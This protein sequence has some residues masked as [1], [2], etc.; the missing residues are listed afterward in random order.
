MQ[1]NIHIGSYKTGSTSIQVFMKRQRATLKENGWIYPHAGCR[2]DNAH[3]LLPFALQ[4]PVTAGAPSKAEEIVSNIIDEAEAAGVDNVILSSEVF[5]SLTEAQVHRLANLFEGHDVRIVA[6]F[7]R[8]DQFLHSFY[9]QCI[10]QSEIR[11]SDKPENYRGFNEITDIARYDKI[12]TWW[13]QAFGK[14]SLILD[15][16]EKERL[17]DGVVADLSL[18]HI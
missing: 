11:L 15:T 14:D 8:Q 16:F 9:M 4:K 5:F 13:E 3:H 7:R 6:Y 2:N 17:V 10:K 12:I 18:I 1:I